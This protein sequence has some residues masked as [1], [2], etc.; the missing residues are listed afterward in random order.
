MGILLVF[1]KSLDIVT[2]SVTLS[3]ILITV[4][5]PLSANKYYAYCLTFYQYLAGH[6]VYNLKCHLAKLPGALLWRATRLRYL[7]S[8]VSG[9]LVI[10]VQRLHQ[11]YGDMVRTA[12][13]EVSFA[14]EDAWYNI[15]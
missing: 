15:F 2:I 12:P 14:R 4:R 8:L 1:S 11:Q 13:D 5:W 3:F 7:Y 9:N 6:I 10:D